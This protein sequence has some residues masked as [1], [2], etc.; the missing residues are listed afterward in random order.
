MELL[1]SARAK[2]QPNKDAKGL[3]PDRHAEPGPS[4]APQRAHRATPTLLGDLPHR[5][6]AVL[7]EG[8]LILGVR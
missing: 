8:E 2:T 7:P 5:G 6:L 3:R 1:R 4:F